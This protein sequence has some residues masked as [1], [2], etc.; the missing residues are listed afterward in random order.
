MG[1]WKRIAPVDR[2]IG[3][4][5]VLVLFALSLGLAGLVPELV[6][7]KLNLWYSADVPRVI[8]DLSDPGAD[9]HRSKLHPLVV[10]LSLPITW[11]MLQLGASQAQAAQLLVSASAGLT[12]LAIYGIGRRIDLAVGEALLLVAAFAASG[13][14]LFWWSIPETFPLGALSLTPALLLLSRGS[15]RP[16]SWL[17]ASAASLAITVPNWLLGLVATAVSQRRLAALRISA[18]ALALVAMLAVLQRQ[19]LPSSSLF[20]LPGGVGGEQRYL[21]RPSLGRA[22]NFLLFTGVAAEPMPVAVAA[23]DQQDRPVAGPP[24][25]GVRS[26]PVH[27]LLQPQRLAAVSCWLL[28]LVN[29]LQAWRQGVQGRLGL[30]VLGFLTA[31]FGLHLVYGEEPFLYAAHFLVPM[32]VIVAL[33]LR[34]RQPT[35]QRGL[36]GLFVLTAAIA[37]GGSLLQACALLAPAVNP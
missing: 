8:G 23:V 7:T 12:G 28:L 20:F 30:T 37:N 33:G 3:I 19:L 10:L 5:I 32:L 34:G 26:G 14:F 27:S 2:L 29:G 31:E 11:P 17:L 13:G 4:G 25:R 1:L 22:A 35:V 6:Q 16:L 9:H 21:S 36:L 15:H 18:G 24:L